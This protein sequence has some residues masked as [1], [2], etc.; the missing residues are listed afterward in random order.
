MLLSGAAAVYPRGHGR[1]TSTLGAAAAV[2][3]G[4]RGRCERGYTSGPL[5]QTSS[6]LLALGMILRCQ[7]IE[8]RHGRCKNSMGV[9][10]VSL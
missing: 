2:Y 3:P 1:C 6:T 9:M 5:R 8:A 10:R 4:G 7:I